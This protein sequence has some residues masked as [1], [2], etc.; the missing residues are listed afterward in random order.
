MEYF[1][2]LWYN[3]LT[4][5]RAKY[6]ERRIPMCKLIKDESNYYE[7]MSFS[8]ALDE[9]IK[10]KSPHRWWFKECIH[11]GNDSYMVTFKSYITPEY[12][13][14]ELLVKVSIIENHAYSFSIVR[15]TTDLTP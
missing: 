3:L 2:I 13:K 8:Y 11:N 4:G 5:C 15:E 10:S 14:F 9:F 6:Y 7:E 1:V 12:S